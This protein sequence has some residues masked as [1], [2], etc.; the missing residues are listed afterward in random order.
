MRCIHHLI[1]LIPNL[2]KISEPLGPLLSKANSKSQNKLDWKDQHTIAFN[3]IKEQIKKKQETSN[4]T[5][6]NKLEYVATQAKKD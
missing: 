6:R 2:A 3:Q 5:Q 4:S 1:K